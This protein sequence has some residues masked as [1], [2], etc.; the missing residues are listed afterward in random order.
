MGNHGRWIAAAGL[1]AMVSI[2]AASAQRDD[3]KAKAAVEKLFAAARSGK[4]AAVL[5]AAEA[6]V[7]LGSVGTPLLLEGLEGRTAPEI[8]IGLRCLRE[9]DGLPEQARVVALFAHPNGAVRAEVLGIA[10]TK[11][12][13]E[14]LPLYLEGAKDQEVTV[15]RRAYDGLVAHRPDDALVPALAAAALSDPDFWLVDRGFALLEGTQPKTPKAA[16]ALLAAVEGGLGGMDG[17]TLSRLF[18][19][20]VDRHPE[21]SRKVVV[22]AIGHAKPEVAIAALRAASTLRLGEAEKPALAQ[23]KS[24]RRSAEV[25]T[26]AAV[27]LGDLG[28]KGACASLVTALESG[29]TPG[30]KDAAA[31]ALRKIT[32]QL[33]G[34]DVAAWKRYLD[35]SGD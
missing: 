31:V 3:G 15:R 13:A 35:E 20:M 8:L 28:A 11:L 6:L 2:G 34:F 33:L 14:G 9:L 26:A 27:L 25:A 4:E 29:A 5:T 10:R 32:G 7:R 24:G 19:W 17:E 30:L 12:G 18:A 16:A 1:A 22:K 23:L 21:P